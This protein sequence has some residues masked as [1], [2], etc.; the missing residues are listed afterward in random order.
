MT[1]YFVTP[2]HEYKQIIRSSKAY[3]YS[4]RDIETKEKVFEVFEAVKNKS[5]TGDSYPEDPQVFNDLGRAT[6]T[7]NQ[8]SL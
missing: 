1:D 6:I 4:K 5:E 7:F 2:T 8:L 3:I